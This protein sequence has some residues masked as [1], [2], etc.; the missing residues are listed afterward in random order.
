MKLGSRSFWGSLKPLTWFPGQDRRLFVFPV[1][2]TVSEDTA[3]AVA[4]EPLLVYS[5]HFLPA[6]QMSLPPT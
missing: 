6:S 4:D 1:T 3:E 2:K 5:C